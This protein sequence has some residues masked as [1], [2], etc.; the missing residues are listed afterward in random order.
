MKNKKDNY[1]T[2]RNSKTPESLKNIQHATDLPDEIINWID[3]KSDGIFVL[4]DIVGEILYITESIKRILGFSP[5]KVVGLNWDEMVSSK[6]VEL[7][8]RKAELTDKTLR[9]FN[10]NVL[11]NDGNYVPLTCEFEY[12][13]T[14]DK[15]IYVLV[16]LK[17]LTVKKEL[18]DM[19]VRS[20]KMN[21]AGQLAAGIAHEIRNPLTSLKG[22]LQLLQAGVNHKEEYFKIMIEEIEKIESITSELLFI[23]KP[24]TDNRT[25]EIISDMINDVIMLLSPQAKQKNIRIV[26][27]GVCNQT[28]VCDRSQIKQVLIN[29]VKNAIEAMDNGGEIIITS[30]DVEDNVIVS[31]I[32]EGIGIPEGILHKLGEPFFTTKQT[33]TGLGLLITKQILEAHNANF[34]VSN[35]HDKGSTFKLV[36]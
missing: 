12:Y 1:V 23:S 10:L 7:A 21:V 30:E 19:M 24:L 6:D 26:K 11:N 14:V 9:K 27:L 3:K 20:E 16:Y 18:E 5:S 35:N 2:E 36:F 28:I 34:E 25:D 22:F 15:Q 29:L 8:R 4:L 17:D 13:R 32:D 33:G 31:V